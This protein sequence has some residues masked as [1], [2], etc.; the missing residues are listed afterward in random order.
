MDE[1]NLSSPGLVITAGL[2]RCLS[3]KILYIR[4]FRRSETSNDS[5]WNGSKLKIAK[6]PTYGAILIKRKFDWTG[7]IG[8]IEIY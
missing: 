2:F 3:L 4:P 6:M 5:L 8:N 1:N 7:R